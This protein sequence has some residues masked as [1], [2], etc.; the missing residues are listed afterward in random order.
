MITRLEIDGFKNFIQTDLYFG[1]FTCVAG[2]NGV[3]KSNLFD[4]IQFISHL[5]D[6]PFTEAATHLRQVDATSITGQSIRG[7]FRRTGT[8]LHPTIRLGIEMLIAPEG[9]DD[10]G[11]SATATYNFLRYELELQLDQSGEQDIIRLVRESLVPIRKGDAKAHLLF[12]HATKWRNE[13]I[14]G[15][16]TVP[17]ISTTRN[18]EGKSLVNLHQDG[19]T[20]GKPQPFAAENLPRTILSTTRYAG[21]HPTAVLVRREMQSWRRLQLEPSALRNPSDLDQLSLR[22]ARLG[23]DGSNIAST[24]YRLANRSS[25]VY[26]DKEEVYATLTNDLRELMEDVKGISVDRDEKR[27]LLVLQVLTKENTL[28]PARSL[29]D[30]TLRFL[31]L[32]ILAMDVQ[33]TGLVC[34]EEPENGIHPER[35]PAILELLQTIP[36]DPKDVPSEENRLRQVIL[37]THS[38]SVVMEVPDDSLLYA[39][40]QERIVEGLRT[41]VTFFKCLRDT[42]RNRAGT[43]TIPRGRLL[44]YLNPRSVESRWYDR[45]EH[46]TRVKERSDL[47]ELQG[48]LFHE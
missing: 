29:S 23:D 11:Q 4:V 18:D 47:T 42:W 45:V 1:P 14:Q 20:G 35:I 5:A 21:E 17:F 34:M 40:L 39:G 32:A 27:R 15:R 41:R 30:G 10:L 19:G 33:E 16:R 36:V 13:I 9:T 28:L 25:E 24:V 8:R 43:P 3:G 2:E 46:Q 26:R 37:N 38:P 6:H 7:I 22:H 31:A 44:A 48:T 12:D